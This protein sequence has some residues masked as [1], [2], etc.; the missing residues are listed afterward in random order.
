[1]PARELVVAIVLTPELALASASMWP[2]AQRSA[3]ARVP[4]AP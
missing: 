1:V 3:Q 4:R 2:I